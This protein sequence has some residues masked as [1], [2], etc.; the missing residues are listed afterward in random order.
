MSLPQGD[1]TLLESDLAKRLLASTIPARLAYVA[2]DGTPRVLS[3]WFHWTGEELVMPTFVSAPHIRRPAARIKTLLA[4]PNIAITIDTESF[5]SNVLL[6]R[7]QVS[8]TEVAGIVPEYALAAQRYL[9]AEAAAEYL[10]QVDQPG[11]TMARIGLRPLW[12]GVLD[13]ETRLPNVMVG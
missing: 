2:A 1:L 5:P 8:I 11:T 3:T 12:V 4:N 13:F 7:G 6:M 10:A 9:G